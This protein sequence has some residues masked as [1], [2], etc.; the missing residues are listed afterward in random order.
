MKGSNPF[1]K[2]LGKGDLLVT[3]F[4]SILSAVCLWPPILT[5]GQKGQT[6]SYLY[7]LSLED[8]SLPLNCYNLNMQLKDFTFTP[9][10]YQTIPSKPIMFL[11]E[12]HFPHLITLP[13]NLSSLTDWPSENLRMSDHTKET[14]RK[15]FCPMQ[16]R[17]KSSF[18][19]NTQPSA[20]WLL[21][22]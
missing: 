7:I 5:L 2:K 11:R 10:A 18:V 20:D 15:Q 14:K 9:S 4:S 17:K 3:A 21:V 8:S 13:V 22:D 6:C 1:G 12:I 16:K 19:Y